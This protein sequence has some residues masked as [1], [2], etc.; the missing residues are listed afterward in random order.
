MF[1]LCILSVLSI[2]YAAAAPTPGAVLAA[3]AAPALPAPII[4]A[5]S[6]QVVARN[7]NTLAAAPIAYAASPVAPLA[8][9]STHA[10]APAAYAA[11]PAYSAPILL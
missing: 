2:V 10:V 3:V 7:Y 6:S 5:S 1:K 9:Y 11:Y 8:A 4:T